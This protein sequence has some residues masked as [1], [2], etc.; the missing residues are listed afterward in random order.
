MRLEVLIDNVRRVTVSPCVVGCVVEWMIILV[1]FSI[2]LSFVMLMNAG[3][4]YIY[5]FLAAFLCT[6]LTMLL[7]ILVK[8]S[9]LSHKKAKQVWDPYK[10]LIDSHFY[11]ID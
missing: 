10:K 7:I 1:L 8:M 9:T 4:G 5:D 6:G 3:T 11:R 2:T